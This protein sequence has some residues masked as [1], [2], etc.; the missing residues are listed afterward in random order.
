MAQEKIL[1][2][3][4]NRE[5]LTLVTE[6]I[7]KPEGYQA[8]GAKDGMKGWRKFVPK[9]RTLFFWTSKCRA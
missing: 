3:D 1:V 7:L 4:D 2:V 6:Y 8:I 5:I 9:V